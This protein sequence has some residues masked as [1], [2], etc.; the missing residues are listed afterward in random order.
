MSIIDLGS[1]DARGIF[2]GGTM[3]AADFLA[4]LADGGEE[5]DVHL[6]VMARHLLVSAL[7]V[8]FAHARSACQSANAVAPEDA[9]HSSIGECNALITYEI[10]NDPDR[11]KVIF[12]AQV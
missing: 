2:D 8:D 6:D 3:G 7:G 4:A 12:T 10:P 11:S 5:L 9:R 1:S